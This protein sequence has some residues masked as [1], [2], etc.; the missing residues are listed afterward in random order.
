MSYRNVVNNLWAPL[1]DFED[2]VTE[3]D[4][5]SVRHLCF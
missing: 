1:E 5:I 4:D 2:R 3:N